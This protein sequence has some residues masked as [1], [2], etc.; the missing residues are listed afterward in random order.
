MKLFIPVL[1]LAV[2][3][4]I[5]CPFQAQSWLQDTTQVNSIS[6][7]A[8][9][10][11]N[12]EFSDHN[13]MRDNAKPYVGAPI[14]GGPYDEYPP[15]IMLQKHHIA[16]LPNSTATGGKEKSERNH[17]SGMVVGAIVGFLAGE[18]IG[19]AVSKANDSCQS[20]T[21]VQDGNN[22]FGFPND[23]NNCLD[24]GTK[25]VLIGILGGVVGGAV[26]GAIG[27]PLK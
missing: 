5:P 12:L 2:L 22:L 14:P 1:L 20:G 3:L 23:G 21:Y 4:S 26:G 27:I 13:R 25:G 19:H 11:N 8:P 16:T 6:Y 10:S 9:K 7:N 17:W 24:R 15:S 18:L